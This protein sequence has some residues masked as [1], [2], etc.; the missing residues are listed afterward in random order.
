MTKTWK[1]GENATGGIITI[2]IKKDNIII[3]NKEWDYSMGS[4]KS[5]D[6]SKAKEL[7]RNIVNS[8]NRNLYRDLYMI[9]TNYTTSYYSEQIIDWVKT[10]VKVVEHSYW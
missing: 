3:I 2:E 7:S 1:L 9:L 10:K 6:Q 5:S 4:N 8:Q